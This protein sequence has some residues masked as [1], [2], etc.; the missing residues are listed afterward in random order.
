MTS[1]KEPVCF[2]MFAL[3]ILGARVAFAQTEIDPKYP[4]HDRARPQPPIVDSGSESSQA[5]PRRPPSDAV[6]LFDGKDLSLWRQKDGSPA[7]WKLGTGYF[8]V[9]PG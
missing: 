5:T 3:A 1:L 9:A 8:E 4:I 6:A 2:A 7:R